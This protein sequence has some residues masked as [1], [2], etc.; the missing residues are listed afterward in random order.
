MA[1]RTGLSWT[2]EARQGAKERA[3]LTRTGGYEL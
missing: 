3:S 1:G 2:S